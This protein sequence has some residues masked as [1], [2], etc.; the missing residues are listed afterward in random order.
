MR[1]E[2]LCLGAHPGSL[3]KNLVARTRNLGAPG[4]RAPVRQQPCLFN[5]NLDITNG[6]LCP[7]N[8]KIYE[9]EPQL[10]PVQR[11]LDLTNEFGQS[12][13]TSLNRGSTVVHTVRYS[14]YPLTPFIRIINE[15]INYLF[16]INY[17]ALVV[18]RVNNAIHWINHYP[19]DSIDYFD[20]TY[21]LDSD[22]S[23]G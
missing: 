22:L 20:N 14:P 9:K 17:L 8:S 3:N 4:D 12:P 18:Q 6:I 23:R 10:G 11:T 19:V 1:M 5:E 21:P 15:L 16:D 7:S 2:N 13:A